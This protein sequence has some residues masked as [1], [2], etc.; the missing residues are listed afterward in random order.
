MKNSTLIR[1]KVPKALYESALEKALLE[2]T[3]KDPKKEAAEK[4]MK[5][6]KKAKAKKEIEAKKVKDAKLKEGMLGDIGSQ[7]A[8]WAYGTNADIIKSCQKEEKG[9]GIEA[10]Q[11]CL[12]RKGVSMAVSGTEPG[13]SAA[14][15]NWKKMGGTA[16]NF[17][18]AE[19]DYK[20]KIGK[21]KI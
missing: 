9:N 5:A 10:F 4:K 16:S 15:G 7:L 17:E 14:G 1:I 2:A 12:R 13:A 20:L 6:E 11:E 8:A 19:K 18:L 3:K 21:T